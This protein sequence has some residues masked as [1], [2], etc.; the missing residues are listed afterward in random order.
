MSRL[1]IG[2]APASCPRDLECWGSTWSDGRR[3][4]QAPPVADVLWTGLPVLL[5]TAGLLI[6]LA[7]RR[8]HRGSAPAIAALILGALAVVGYV[9]IYVVDFVSR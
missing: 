2:C 9:A 5:G 6:G 1:W 3:I 4:C 7:G 8:A